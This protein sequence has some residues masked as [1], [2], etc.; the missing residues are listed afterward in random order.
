[1][2]KQVSIFAT[3]KPGQV[4]KVVDALS[5]QGIDIRAMCVADTQDFGIIRLIVSDSQKAK[6]AI[7]S[8]K[9]IVRITNVVGIKIPDKPGATKKA[10]ELLS[11]NKINIDYMYAFVTKSKEYAYFVMRVEDPEAAEKV[12]SENG[13]D[14]VTQEDIEKL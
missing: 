13:V 5:E 2:I 6:E 3:N 8:H 10:L 7:S 14:L 9:C 11:E 1:M 4:V 12:L